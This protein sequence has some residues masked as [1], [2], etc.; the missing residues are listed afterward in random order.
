MDRARV[1]PARAPRAV[2][3]APVDAFTSGHRRGAP[4]K[5]GV[6]T[7]PQISQPWFA[8]RRACAPRRSRARVGS[9]GPA[10]RPSPPALRPVRVSAALSFLRR[11]AAPTGRQRRPR[12]RKQIGGPLCRRAGISGRRGPSAAGHFADSSDHDP[13]KTH[14][15]PGSEPL[16]GQQ[17]E[18]PRGGGGAA[19]RAGP[20]SEYY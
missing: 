14:G 3:S 19:G 20:R 4:L 13:S 6:E 12:F 5:E 1:Q 16:P 8:R 10:T 2:P 7:S 18:R 17:Q 9:D 15:S 11:R